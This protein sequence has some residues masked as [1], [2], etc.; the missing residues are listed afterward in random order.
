MATRG[1][2]AVLY[3]YVH[4]RVCVYVRVCVCAGFSGADLSNLVNEAALLAAKQ[5]AEQITPGMLDS[6]FDKI[7]MGV[8]RKSCRRTPESIKRYVGGAH[9]DTHTY[10]HTQRC[11]TV[12]RT[13]T[14]AR[15]QSITKD[16][17]AGQ[18]GQARGALQFWFRSRPYMPLTLGTGQ[19]RTALPLVIVLMRTL[20]TASRYSLAGLLMQG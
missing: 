18:A 7:R 10:A 15:T 13:G 8:E 19:V 1:P 2:Y 4:V 20:C 16:R 9:T 17:H 6:A 14:H 3:V 11:V 5:G 12:V